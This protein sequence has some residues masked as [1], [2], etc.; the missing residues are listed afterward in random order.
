MVI[1]TT[2]LFLLKMNIIIWDLRCCMVR[3]QCNFFPQ[4]PYVSKKKNLVVYMLGLGFCGIGLVLRLGIRNT[5][6]VS[7]HTVVSEHVH[8]VV[9]KHRGV[10]TQVCNQCCS[11]VG[12]CR[13]SLPRT[14]DFVQRKTL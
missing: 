6:V 1:L 3:D 8:T 2:E 12:R 13:A 10:G 4:Q 11:H 9:T 14:T 5:V 7:E